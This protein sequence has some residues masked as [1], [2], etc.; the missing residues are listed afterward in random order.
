VSVVVAQLG[1]ALARQ[2][3]ECSVVG[4]PSI[5]SSDY[6]TRASAIWWLE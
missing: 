1:V 4:H 5:Q 3:A 6:R 2:P